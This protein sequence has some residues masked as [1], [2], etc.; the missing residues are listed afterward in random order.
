[1]KVLVL[2][3]SGLVGWNLLKTAASLGHQVT[4]TCR[5]HPQPGLVPLS[6][7]DGAA[8]S[9]LIGETKPDV[10][11]YCAGWTWVDGCESDPDR[12]RR[13]NA[14]CPGRAARAA[15]ETGSHFVYFSTSYVFNGTDGPYPEEA[16][17]APL[18]V[19]GRAKLEGEQ[20]VREATGGRALI[21]RTMGVYGTEP[22]QKNFVYQVRQTLAAGKPMRVPEDQ[23]GNV[24]YVDDLARMAI[25]LARQDRRGIWNLAGPDPRV[26]RSDFARQI[27]QA[28]DLPAEL[29]EPVPTASLNQPAPRP[30]E[31]G[32]LIEKACRATSIAPAAWTKIP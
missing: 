12:A 11:F 4:G 21:A 1:M 17:T 9:R 10:I 2:G 28:Y 22:Q 30:R 25:E 27:A 14:D 32:L 31:G 18:S 3:A 8:V 24:T 15:S 29:I 16:A 20:Q 6:M 7:E 26:R 23:F 5:S 19:Y 13:E